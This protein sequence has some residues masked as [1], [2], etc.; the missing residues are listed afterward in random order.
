[1]AVAEASK[2]RSTDLQRYLELQYVMNMT[3]AHLAPF[4]WADDVSTRAMLT[5]FRQGADQDPEP[6]FNARSL[7]NKKVKHL[8]IMR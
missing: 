3:V 4:A 5:A 1:M 8:I 6:S 2:L 7:H